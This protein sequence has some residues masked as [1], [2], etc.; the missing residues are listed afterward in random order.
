MLFVVIVLSGILLPMANVYAVCPVC[1]VAVG[2]GV[3]LSRWLGIDDLITGLWVGGLIVSLIAWT[4]VWLN[5]INIRFYGR[6]ILVSLF[7]YAI[8]ILPLYKL[9]IMGLSDNKIL[10]IDKLL[11]GTL[12]GSVLFTSATV[13]SNY[14][15]KLNF[16]KSY[17]MGQKIL[18]P[19]GTL[20][21]CSIIFYIVV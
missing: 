10:N 18:L 2:F 1:A 4:I 13:Y 5:K 3:G 14:L 16:G 8:T 17:F 11:L 21:I 20:L 7:Y 19:I 9:N 15:K 12:L 6:K